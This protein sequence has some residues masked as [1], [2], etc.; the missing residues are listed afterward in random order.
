MKSGAVSCELGVG[1]WE[2]GV[3]SCELRVGSCELGVGSWELGVASCE[4]CFLLP[5]S[6]S[7]LT[8]FYLKG[9]LQEC[10]DEVVECGWT[11]AT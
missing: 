2:L 10:H 5:T 4:F 7:L 11:L 9:G 6:Y 8:D 3:G 1:S